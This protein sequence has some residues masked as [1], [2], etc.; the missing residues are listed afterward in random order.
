MPILPTLTLLAALPL[1]LGFVAWPEAPG[2]RAG[3]CDR[4][5]CCE[6]DRSASR[7][8]QDRAAARQV[9]EAATGGKAVAFTR[10][11]INGSTVWGFEVR[12]HMPGKAKGWR[13]L[14]DL[15]YP[16]KVYNKY[17]IPNPPPPR[18]EA[19]D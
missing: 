7:E 16:P 18:A 3:S 15:D 13:C 17:E 10:I 6:Q 5:A 1:A 11:R 8:K 2:D 9:A 19:A 12:V 14:V 4:G